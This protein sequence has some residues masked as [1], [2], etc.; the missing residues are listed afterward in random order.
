MKHL[1]LGLFTFI[2]LS[3]S[4]P[5][6]VIVFLGDSITANWSMERD[7]PG[8]DVHNSGV[9]REDTTKMLARFQRD[10]ID[11]QPSVVY[12]L[13]G[14]NDIYYGQSQEV[15]EANIRQMIAVSQEHRIQVV[16]CSVLPTEPSNYSER[17]PE[18]ITALNDWLQKTAAEQHLRYVNYY[19]AFAGRAGL[20]LDGIH[21]NAAGYSIMAGVIKQQ[22]SPAT[23][24]RY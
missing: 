4:Q 13:A 17:P 21:P 22:F 12:I 2:C 9:G 6:P 16:L 8:W 1:M 20:T 5:R 23:S 10:V 24:Q 7:F 3:S 11:Y 18:R 19:A 15:T 14:T